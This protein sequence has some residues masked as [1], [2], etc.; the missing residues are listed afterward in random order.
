MSHAKSCLGQFLALGAGLL[1]CLLTPVA[2]AKSEC[3]IQ[4]APIPFELVDRKAVSTLKLNGHEAK[5]YI[6][7][8]A[9]WSSISE[10][11]A[12][13][14]GLRK[15]PAP[16]GFSMQGIG[17]EVD[18]NI[19][20]ANQVEFLG[21]TLK[22]IEFIAGG[23]DVGAGLL[24]QNVLF[25]VEDL[26]LDLSKGIVNLVKA[27]NCSGKS[28][29]Y[30]AKP[31]VRY[32][33]AHLL[34]DDN[35]YR[36]PRVEVTLNGQHVVALIDTGAASTVLARR[37]A[38][39]AG[40]NVDS[41][42]ATQ[43]SNTYGVGGGLIKSWKVPVK[44]MK[45][46]TET[47]QNTFVSVID[48]DLSDVDMLLGIDFVLAH[49]LLISYSQ[50]KVYMTYNGGRVY[51]LADPPKSAAK[52]EAKADES[53]L[54]T[55]DE[56]FKRGAG[57][58]E[59]GETQEALKNYDKA[60]QFDP[61]VNRYRLARA[62]LLLNQGYSRKAL[63][64]VDDALS[65]EPDW[66]DALLLR[67]EIDTELGNLEQK[68]ADRRHL[69]T[70]VSSGSR[71]SYF[72]ARSMIGDGQFGQALPLLNDWLSKH[73]VDAFRIP[74]LRFRCLSKAMVNEDIKGAL[75][76]CMQVIK[77]DKNSG[78]TLQAMGFVQ[79]R[80]GNYKD[81]SDDFQKAIQA[82]SN[83]PW[84]PYGLALCYQKLSQTESARDT[85]KSIKKQFKSHYATMVRLGFDLDS[86]SA[87]QSN[88]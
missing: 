84:A 23:T 21:L 35:Q 7:T 59:R 41:P 16:V 5:F 29:A 74:A 58:D 24:G 87:G 70:V 79:Y 25:I 67:L 37:A 69:L 51:A 38:K 11:K 60:I 6:D 66:V 45:I 28:L 2:F 12:D 44:E 30:W 76:D 55:A 73:S 86:I 88:P 36:R 78:L 9:F 27:Q 72:I 61:A 15:V 31:P 13:E 63:L 47:I 65:R 46:G 48:Q 68:D 19:V 14:F 32:E 8:G 39:K 56:Y 43:I 22:N 42:E 20:R 81:A 57:Q 33:E 64:D 62:R 80:L 40:I 18:A 85:L 34:R 26:D 10:A 77:D 4:S 3:R 71:E 83:L 75:K 1:V 50:H 17:G 49:H 82:N 53:P 54:L 52:E